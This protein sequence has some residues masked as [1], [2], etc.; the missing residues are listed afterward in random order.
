MSVP[1]VEAE[2]LSREF[3]DTTAV[4]ALNLTIGQG[5]MFA[6]VGPDGAGKTTTLKMFCGALKPTDGRLR[7]LGHDHE[8]E[9]KS[10]KPLIGYLSQRFSLYEDLSVDENLEFFAEIHGIRDFSSQREKLLEF[11]RLKP[12]RDR[13]AGRLS[14][15]MKQKLSLSCILIHTPRIIFMD[16]PT[17]GV[18]PVSRREFWIILSTLLDSG[19]T[20]VMTTP[21]MDEAERCSRVGLMNNGNLM[22]A[23][24]PAGIKAKMNGRVVELVCDRPRDALRV[25]SV[26]PSITEIQAFGDRLHLVVESSE[27]NLTVVKSALEGSGIPFQDI[28]FV[29][30]TLDNVFI[31]ILKSERG[32]H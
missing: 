7:I 20:I 31:S 10:I 9:R 24:T 14:G 15:G 26:V 28:R 19:I 27:K 17:T 6:L 25:L 8:K 13:L 12:F 3:K 2:N 11:T 32:N 18:D 23:D 22:T 5:E 1:A 4:K 16:E 30:P 21:Y 29:A